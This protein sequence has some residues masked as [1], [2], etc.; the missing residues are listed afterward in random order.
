[1]SEAIEYKSGA[2]QGLRVLDL[3]TEPPGSLA[4]MLLADLGADVLRAQADGDPRGADP[5]FLCWNRNKRRVSP[6]RAQELALVADVLV[7]ESAPPGLEPAALRARNPGLIYVTLP[8]YG[9]TGPYAELPSDHALLAGLGG[10]SFR[11]FSW[12]DVPVYLVTPQLHYAHG[13]LAASAIASCIYERDR[14]GQGQE[15]SVSGLDAVAATSSNTLTR[16]L[17]GETGA[18]E[19]TNRQPGARGSVPNFRLYQCADG[20]WLFLGTLIFEH[21][22]RALDALDLLDILVME[23]IDGEFANVMSPQNAGRVIA[24]LDARF[25]ERPLD[26]W[27][28][29]FREHD[30]PCGPVGTRKD[31]FA[32]ETVA[33]NEMRVGVDHPQLG[34]VELPGVPVKLSETPGQVRHLMCDAEPPEFAPRTDRPQTDRPLSGGASAAE[35]RGPLAGVRILDLGN[36]IA[37]PFA[38]TVLANFGAD[39]I[40]VEP[41]SGDSFRAYELD[42]IGVN[43]GKRSLA[44]DMK[45]PEGRETFYDLV[46]H[47]DVVCD[48]YRH[49]VLERLGIDYDALRAVN[50]RIISVS[51]TSYGPVGLLSR[52]PGFDPT[53]QARS[54]LARA[55]GGDDEPAFNAIPVSDV[56]SALLAAFGIAVA[57]HAREKTGRGQKVETCLANASVLTQS[58]EL[59]WYEGRVDPPLGD[60]DCRG[61]SALQRLYP[62]AD[63]WLVLS[64]TSDAHYRALCGALGRDDWL[65]RWPPTAAGM[66]PRDGALAAALTEALAKLPRDH[67]LERLAAAGVPAAPA[68]R[69]ADVYDSPLFAANDFFQENLYPSQGPICTVRGFARFERTPAG[70]V[71]RCP[72]LGE[73]TRE[74]LSEAGLTADHIARLLQSGIALESAEQT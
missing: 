45:Q 28:A 58:G 42:V 61:V 1:V 23:G 35:A 66:E 68:V 64:C 27:L 19:R 50:P 44:L 72:L 3:C 30:V 54:G 18:A 71:R 67:A 43:Q 16:P 36:I 41:L 29:L 26:A 2:F 53:I 69:A 25:A 6:D 47:A 51:V 62:C 32:S 49:G 24:R 63:G 70:F 7:A 52:D 15:L 38:S 55:Q 46:R 56:A 57:L 34:R 11:Q 31:W 10:S 39:V 21:F 12:E 40:K 37:G 48:N 8:P 74:V 4:C 5:G 60:R 14:S 59:T 22:V 17:T 13:I 9:R 20:G 65:E 73:H 33:A